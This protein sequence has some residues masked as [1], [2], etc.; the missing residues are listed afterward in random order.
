MQ[1]LMLDVE[2]VHGQK[3]RQIIVRLNV[4][5]VRDIGYRIYILQINFLFHYEKHP[6]K[7][8]LIFELFLKNKI[9][10]LVEFENL[11]NVS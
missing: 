8:K 9:L 7:K 10:F 2:K 6:I 11:Y 3:V 4:I 1:R 5:L